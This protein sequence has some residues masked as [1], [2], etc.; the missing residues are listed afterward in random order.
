MFE[1]IYIRDP[2]NF[3]SNHF[4]LWAQ[5]LL[6][7]TYYNTGYLQGRCTLPLVL[8]Q[9]R[10]LKL[11]DTKFQALKALETA[12]IPH[13]HTLTYTLRPQ[14]M[15]EG[16][17]RLI[18]TRANNRRQPDHDRNVDRTLTRVVWK[19]LA[20]DTCCRVEVAAEEVGVWLEY[21]QINP[22]YL[23]GSYSLLKRW[24]QHASGQQP[25]PSWT[26]SEKVPGDY[27]AL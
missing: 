27:V 4:E 16:S 3:A 14:W 13:S 7:P 23:Q 6:N 11:I 5:L 17:L 24:H 9:T 18:D 2:R 22:S 8:P 21:P 26:D 25:K 10:F 12:S 19:S 1:T 20:V 15:S